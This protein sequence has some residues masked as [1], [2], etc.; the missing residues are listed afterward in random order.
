MR[1][2]SLFQCTYKQLKTYPVNSVGK[3]LYEANS[4]LIEGQRECHFSHSNSYEQYYHNLHCRQ[5]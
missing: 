2:M 4:H 3:M 1:I 5:T